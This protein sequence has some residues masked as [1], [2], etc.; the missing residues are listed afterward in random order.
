MLVPATFKLSVGGDTVG[1]DKA[2]VSRAVFSPERPFEKKKL[3]L[4]FDI[5]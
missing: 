3:A 2:T 1:G 4:F 5:K